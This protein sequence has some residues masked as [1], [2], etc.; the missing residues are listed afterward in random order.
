MRP[1]RLTK[2]K[3]NAV[4]L[5]AFFLVQISLIGNGQAMLG[6]AEVSSP[7]IFMDRLAQKRCPDHFS[8]S[9]SKSTIYCLKTKLTLP[10]AKV[11]AACDDLAKGILGFSWASKTKKTKK[12]TSTYACPTG[13]KRV[14]KKGVTHCR[15]S[16]LFV[17]KD[18]KTLRPYCGYLKR[19]YIGY[20]YS[21]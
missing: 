19:G 15:F 5:C 11:S 9:L 3:P 13:S 16:E 1:S 2:K 10:D 20:S 7:T 12:K 18:S 8:L 4:Y 17:P 21:L 14:A 6:W